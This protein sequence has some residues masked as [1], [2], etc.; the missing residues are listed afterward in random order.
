LSSFLI[1]C[2][3]IALSIH[4]RPEWL[5]R[6]RE[7]NV[8]MCALSAA[9]I[10]KWL[11]LFEQVGRISWEKPIDDLGYFRIISLNEL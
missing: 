3:T 1:D 11:K 2:T 6:E 9:F 7:E 4:R 5:E 10:I 8:A